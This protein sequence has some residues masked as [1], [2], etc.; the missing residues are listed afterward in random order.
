MALLETLS[1]M[2]L[3]TVICIG[4]SGLWETKVHVIH[5]SELFEMDTYFWT[6]NGY[7]ETKNQRENNFGLF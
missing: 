1:L 3:K 5:I 6:Y 7:E 4:I 2:H